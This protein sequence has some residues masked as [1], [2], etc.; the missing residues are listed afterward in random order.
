MIKKK[1]LSS[2]KY[3]A[4]IASSID[5]KIS[6]VS[7][8]MPDWTSR[9]D[10]NFLQNSLSV[11]D[12]VIV[13][14]N[15]YVSAKA[16]LDKRNTYVLSSKFTGIKKV[17]KVKFVNP[18]NVKLD[19]EFKNYK[20]VAILGGGRVFQTMLNL[21]L[22]DDVYLTIEPLIF[23]R[24]KEMFVGGKKIVKIKLIST[25]TLNKKGSL[26]LHYKILKSLK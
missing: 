12:A 10:W 19:E 17:G 16:R 15:T 22:L 23:G 5:G 13:G 2:T 21:N 14:R 3:T 7:K 9:E 20:K 24:G 25:K 6:L 18:K 11:M 8:V 1:S 4:F 26:L